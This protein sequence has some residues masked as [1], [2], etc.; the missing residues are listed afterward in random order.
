MTATESRRVKEET[1]NVT[2]FVVL[3]CAICVCGNVLHSFK[4]LTRGCVLDPANCRL[5]DQQRQ[6][7]HEQQMKQQP[8]M[9][10]DNDADVTIA[11]VHALIADTLLYTSQSLNLFM[12]LKFNSNFKSV[13]K[14]WVSNLRMNE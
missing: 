6:L 10:N 11:K 9:L 2:Y 12:Y 14:Q 13:F 8:S 5:S 7:M 3:M 4:F 1:R